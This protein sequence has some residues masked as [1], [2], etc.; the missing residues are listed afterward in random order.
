MYEV[1]QIS[2][3]SNGNIHFREK[4]E[5]GEY[6]SQNQKEDDFIKYRGSVVPFYGSTD[7]T[8]KFDEKQLQY[9]QHP[10]VFCRCAYELCALDG[11]LE[12]EVFPD[13]VI[14]ML[15]NLDVS[16]AKRRGI[17]DAVLRQR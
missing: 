9:V 12:N 17:K 10:E 14:G 8:S 15:D 4:T 7:P 16:P 11:C 2:K 3:K 6:K 5:L 1:L 13:N